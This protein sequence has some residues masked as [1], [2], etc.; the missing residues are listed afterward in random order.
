M[1]GIPA[2]LPPGGRVL[3]PSTK[4]HQS[5]LVIHFG[6]TLDPPNLQLV[7]AVECGH[8]VGFGERRIIEDG[9]AEVF[10]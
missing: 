9:V 10:N 2:T 1:Y 6:W 8:F 5:P 3:R 7:E 4:A